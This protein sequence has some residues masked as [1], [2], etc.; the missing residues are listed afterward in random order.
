MEFLKGFVWEYRFILILILAMVLFCV[1][2][3]QKAKTIAYA[4]ML[5]AKSLAKDAVL[6]SGAQQEEWVVRKTY[7]FLP[8]SLTI[9]LNE[10]RMRTLVHYLYHKAKDC[11]DDGKMNNSIE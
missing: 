8:K 2:E 11:L 10:D 6:K 7:Q 1:F 9:F 5:Q 3:W 4:L